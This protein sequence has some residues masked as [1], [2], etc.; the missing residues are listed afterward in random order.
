MPETNTLNDLNI[1]NHQKVIV[2][3][4]FTPKSAFILESEVDS[5]F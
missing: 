4:T 3:T 2:S 5:S 1:K